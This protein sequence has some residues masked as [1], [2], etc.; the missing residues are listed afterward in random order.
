MSDTTYARA[1]KLASV[2]LD[3]ASYPPDESSEHEWKLR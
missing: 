2:C 1:A 3:A